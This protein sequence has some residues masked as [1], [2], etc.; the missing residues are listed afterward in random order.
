MITKS[1][2]QQSF[3]IISIEKRRKRFGMKMKMKMK[4]KINEEM[5]SIVDF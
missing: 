3:Y 5:D 2:R 1:L 4:M